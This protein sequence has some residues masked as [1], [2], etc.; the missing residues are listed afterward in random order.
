MP[1]AVFRLAAPPTPRNR[2]TP[3]FF[4]AAMIDLWPCDEFVINLRTGDAAAWI[5]RADDRIMAGKQAGKLIGLRHVGFSYREIFLRRD[6]L[7]I[8]DDRCDLMAALQRLGKNFRA[9]ESAGANKR[10]FH[11]NLPPG[12]YTACQLSRSR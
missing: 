4:T 7:R 10:D 9:H 12:L 11:D 2:L 6:F 8:A 1:S 5:E 3:D